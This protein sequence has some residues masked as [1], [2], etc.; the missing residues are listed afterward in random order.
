MTEA[1]LRKRDREIEAPPESTDVQTQK[2][3]HGEETDEFLHLIDQTLAEDDEEDEFSPSEEV[4][5]RVMRSLEEEIGTTCSTSYPSPNSGYDSAATDISGISEGLTRD[6]DLDVDLCYLVEASGDDLGIPTSPVWDITEEFCRSSEET[7]EEGLTG[8]PNIKSLCENWHF[9]DEFENHQL[10]E[11][12]EHAW[13][14][15]HLE[16]H[17]NIDSV[18]QVMLFDG[19][20]FSAA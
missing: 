7:Q 11:F 18:S 13:D 19:E 15:T 16:D 8:N 20:S 12:Y 6:T 9:V 1:L 2:R 3:F 17:L 14:A 10:F 5:N 4:V